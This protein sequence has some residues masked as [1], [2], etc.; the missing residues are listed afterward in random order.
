VCGGGGGGGER[1]GTEGVGGREREREVIALRLRVVQ[2]LNAERTRAHLPLA[3]A[4]SLSLS[5]SLSFA[6]ALSLSRS[7][8]GSV[9]Y[10]LCCIPKNKSDRRDCLSC[11]RQ[12][13]LA[14]VP[15]FAAICAPGARARRA[16]RAHE[17]QGQSVLC[18]SRTLWAG[19]RRLPACAH[20]GGRSARPHPA[21]ML[22]AS[23]CRHARRGLGVPTDCETLVAISSSERLPLRCSRN[24]HTCSAWHVALLCQR[25][26]TRYRFQKRRHTEAPAPPAA[27]TH[28]ELELVGREPRHGLSRLQETLWWCCQERH[29]DVLS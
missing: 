25:V 16:G 9:G 24:L 13:A 17:S 10:R 15:G 20:G 28:Q 3:R 14:H 1:A 26:R 29:C 23:I 27:C 8:S 4:L 19:P 5:L 22:M 6:R 21:Q 18:T 11:V 7:L 12:R 2:Y